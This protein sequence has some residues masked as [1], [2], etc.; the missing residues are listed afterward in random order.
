MLD[1]MF[2]V[3]ESDIIGVRIDEDV[4]AGKKAI[5]YVRK[6]EGDEAKNAN[7]AA[8]GDEGDKAATATTVNTDDDV[9]KDKAYA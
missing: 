3:P 7:A 8:V 6:K 4:I 1:A 9:R 2:E 5:E